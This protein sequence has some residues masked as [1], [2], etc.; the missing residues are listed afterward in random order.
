[1]KKTWKKILAA[2]CAAAMLMTMPG[3]YVLADEMRAANIVTETEELEGEKSDLVQFDESSAQDIVGAESIIVGD[4]VTASVDAE[5][6]VV[7]LSSD[8]GTLWRDWISELG[9]NKSKITAIKASETSGTIYLPNDCTN[10]FSGC[11]RL[12]EIDLKKFNTSN[13]TSMAGMFRECVSL[14][15]IDVSNFDTSN[16]T[17]MSSMFMN[18]SS[19]EQLDLRSF[20]TSNVTDMEAMF[21]EC[22]S[23]KSLDVSSFKTS[24][25][26]DMAFLFLRCSNLTALDV[27]GFETSNV[28]N[29]HGMFEGCSKLQELDVNDFDTSSAIR[30]ECMFFG[31][32]SL[33]SLDVS[34]FDT[35]I[36]QRI[37]QIFCGCSNLTNL[38]LSN[39]D[40]SKA[41]NDYY[42]DMLAGCSKLQT[43]KTPKKNNKSDIVLPV[44]MYDE[45]GTEY[46]NLPI[47]DYSIT[48]TAK[49]A[50][51]TPTPIPTVTPT[52]VPTETP[53]PAPI[54]GFSDVQ[55]LSHP[56]YNAIYWAAEK[57]ITKGYSD[58]TFGINRSCTR[59]EMMMFLWRFAGKPSPKMTSKSPFKDVPNKGS[60]TINYL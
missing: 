33:Q 4:G 7:V 40:I 59:G 21:W 56:Y 8:S 39:F 20:N 34:G 10:M 46:T 58:G 37:Y 17:Y 57:N 41:Q 44:S 9:I 42:Y 16:V 48:L 49:K 26:E 5:T 45:S 31:C 43:L 55:N 60:G 53:S 27:S 12:E 15:S 11:G 28:K 29:M 14:A 50:D 1:M 47:L 13:V 3:M 52:P 6:G 54:N 18:C 2:G 36:V 35:S 24:R 32:S 30:M 25:V 38:D 23:L 19:L 51:V 22:S